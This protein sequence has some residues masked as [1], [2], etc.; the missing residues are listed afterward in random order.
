MF[1]KKVVVT[2]GCG[3]IGGAVVRALVNRGYQVRVI[4]DLSKAARM[5]P[6]GCELIQ[7]DLTDCRATE[8]AFVGFDV[9]VNLAA[10]LG[11]I[12]FFHRYPATV[13]DQN[14]KIYSS[15]FEAAVHNGYKRMIYFS[16]SM[17]FEATGQFPSRE[18]DLAQIPSP[19]TAYGFSKLMGERYCQA[20]WQ[21][22]HLPYTILRPFNAFGIYEKPGVE[23][24]DA[25]VIPDLIRKVLEGQD[26][27]EILG[28]GEQTRCF[29]H[30]DDV[31]GATVVAIEQ[32]DAI[33]ED[34]N[35]GTQV[36]T[37]ILDLVRMICRAC[38][39]VGEP[40][41]HFVPSFEY[42]IRRRVP[43]VEK[44]WRLLGWK[45]QYKLEDRLPEIVTWIKESI[46]A[47]S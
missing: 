44:A 16:S 46:V 35:I 30:V 22:F 12:G 9:C 40:R 10:K 29:T 11:G 23:V 8:Q 19:I 6:P 14:N 27:V 15:T 25:H 17:V 5:P 33:N 45:P 37:R 41:F 24:G 13:L 43:D 34:F 28:D 42:D 31:A 39:R 32:E 47:K 26:P 20:F 21:E 36:E 3:F 7:M 38:G 18:S 1:C 2:G 4:D